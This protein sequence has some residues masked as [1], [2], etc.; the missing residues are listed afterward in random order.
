MEPKQAQPEIIGT[1]AHK[2]RIGV[3]I[4]SGWIAWALWALTLT[5]VAAGLIFALAY[6]QEAPLYEFW[7]VA[8]IGPIFATLGA[9]IVSR[10]PA[11]VIGWIFC[12]PSAAGG[13]Q[14]LSGQ[15]ATVALFSESSRLPA[16]T[17]AAWLSTVTQTLL[18]SS[19]FF[20]VLL[21]P[22]GRLPSPRWRVV[23][24]TGGLAIAAWV[25]SRALHPGP[26]E[27]FPSAENPFGVEAATVVD[28]L[29]S[30][31]TW[32]G[33]ACLVAAIVSLALRFYRSR[34]EE[35]LQLKWFFYAATL[36][37]LAILLL[38]EGP[39]GTLVWALAPLGLAVAAALAILRYRL[40]D[41][42]TLINRTLV[43]GALTACVV[44]I[45]VLIVGYLGAMFRTGGG[46]PISLVAAG[47]VAVLFAPLRERLQ[48]AVNRLMYGERD[49]P[50]AV[51]SR[52]GERLEAT[53]EPHAVLPAVA[54]TVAQA[55]KLPHVAIELKRGDGYETVAEHGRRSG[56]PLRRPL[57]YG[58]ETVGRINLSP[59]GPGEPFG[60]A[61][62]R[63][64]EDLSRQAG[65]AAHAVRL[66]DDLQRS[67]ERLVSAREEERRRLRR[68]LH[69][70][71]GPALSSAMLKLGAAR[72]S[73]SSSSPADD[74]I[75]EVRDDLRATV[76]D[77]RGM[78]YD[79]RPPALDQLGL[80]PAI[81]DYAQQCASENE[82]GMGVTVDAPE[83]LPPLP[84][85]VE[86]AAYYIARE[87]ITN[88]AQHARA[89]S[90]HVCLDLQDDLERVELRMEI[91]D[92]GVGV[93][94]ERHLGVGLSSMR[95]RAEELGGQ[96]SVESPPGGGTRTVAR[97][98]VGKE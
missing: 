90:C 94:G 91:T 46:L 6:R 97:L 77:V 1:Q 75:C 23:A 25:L 31:G 81:R 68:N 56:E 83:R 54:E 16:G 33:P 95:E 64:L 86:V 98:P 44:G 71:L 48:R 49:D 10:R 53:L 38:G 80:V 30:V 73:L 51:L 17:I 43:Y 67:R 29:G 62:L 28:A 96:F 82:S 69:D 14:M 34:G 41:I 76:A 47:V 40:Y 45:Y 12:I 55:L 50:Y 39:L 15:Y 74:L 87:A 84:A 13:I 88:V 66:T 70:G 57:V 52:L 18:V 20:L 42:D 85:A 59:R 9:L 79:L 24:W 58:T 2:R 8:M 72:R 89:R 61:D 78:V 36:G 19:M 3:R 63:L 65:V 11:N 37:F 32:L 4:P 93:H 7:V 35:R 21:F 92:D 22:T 27:A 60:P 26:L 5:L